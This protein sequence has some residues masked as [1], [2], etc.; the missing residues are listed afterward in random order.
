MSKL[1]TR[2]LSG[3]VYVAV[4][5]AAIWFNN[6]YTFILFGLFL[7]LGLHEFFK[8]TGI[9][10]RLIPLA[11]IINLGLYVLL[12]QLWFHS[13]ILFLF[14]PIILLFSQ[15]ILSPKVE[16]PI[17]QIGLCLMPLFYLALPFTFGV[18][19]PFATDEGFRPEV[20]FGLFIL[21]W[22]NDTFAYLIGSAIG[23]RKLIERV[24]PNK[25]W[26]GSIGGAICTLFIGFLLQNFW[27][28][29]QAFAWPLLAILIGIFGTL[30]DLVES[31]LKRSAGVKDSG[32][33]MPGH[34]G[35]LDRLDSFV[36]ASPVVYLTLNLI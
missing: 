33:I 35:I 6:F 28:M 27:P 7:S 21:I 4:L 16:Q 26:E 10:K 14:I 19:M 11:L 8:L 32:T 30:G 18:R 34:G 29:P 17:R 3:S 23:K 20:L 1:I 36:F 25:T 2:S 5:F 12:N 24:S 13:Y 22:S 15:A 31:V 9:S